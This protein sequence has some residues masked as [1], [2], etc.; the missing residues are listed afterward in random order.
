MAP[1]RPGVVDEPLSTMSLIH[2]RGRGF[3]QARRPFRCWLHPP[4]RKALGLSFEHSAFRIRRLS[5]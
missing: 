3:F 5:V 1:E 4:Y 2:G